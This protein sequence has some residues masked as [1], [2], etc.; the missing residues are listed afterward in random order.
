[1]KGYEDHQRDCNHAPIE[2]ETALKLLAALCVHS[3]E[4]K[5]NDRVLQ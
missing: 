2:H 1:M 3:S 4:R 5:S